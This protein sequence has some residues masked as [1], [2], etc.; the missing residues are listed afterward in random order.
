MKNFL[1]LAF[2]NAVAAMTAAFCAIA[3]NSVNSVNAVT[4]EFQG[5]ITPIPARANIGSSYSQNDINYMREYLEEIK[6]LDKKLKREYDE[7][8]IIWEKRTKLEKTKLERVKQKK[9]RKKQN[10]KRRNI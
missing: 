5:V 2:V 9:V 4:A 8:L 3:V 7:A 10:K 6:E 1:T